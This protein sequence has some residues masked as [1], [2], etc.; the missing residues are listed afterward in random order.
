MLRADRATLFLVD[1][2]TSEIWSK[3]AQGAGM[4]EIRVP[5]G[6]GI[7]GTVAATG[8]TINIP[9]AYADPRFNPEVDRRTGY[10]T[11]TILCAPIRDGAGRGGRRGSQV[12][13]K[14][15]GPFTRDDEE[16]LAA[17][18]AQAFIALD[19]ARL[20]ESVV[21][22]KNYNESILSC[23]ATGVLTLDSYGVVTGV[24]PGL[25]SDLRRGRRRR[26]RPR[27]PGPARRQGQRGLRGATGHLCA[28]RRGHQP[29]TSSATT[30]SG[31]ESVNVNVSV[32]PL[33]DSKGQSLGVVVVADDITQEQRLMST[34][35]RYVTR[36]IAEEVLKS[37]GRCATGRH[38]PAGVHPVLR[39]PELHGDQRA[40]P[41]PEQ[42]V[43]FLNDYFSSWCR[44][45]S[46]SRARSTSSSATASWRC[47]ARP[48]AAPTIRCARCGPR[49]ACGAAC[50]AS[51]RCQRER[52][53]VEIEIGI[54]IS[55]GES[56]SGNI[57]SEQRMEYTVIGD[58]VNL[59]SRLE[60][61]TKNHPY[62]ILINDQIY[63]QVKDTF[64]CVLLGE[65]FVK[66]KAQAV[67]VY[68][69]ADPRLSGLPPARQRAREHRQRQ[70]RP[71]RSWPG[72]PTP[73]GSRP[74]R[75]SAAAVGRPLLVDH[76]RPG[77]HHPGLARQDFLAPLVDAHG[78][79][80]DAVALADAPRRPRPGR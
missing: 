69:V 50:A 67:R 52:G 72:P 13:N 10:R 38:T 35:C 9:D 33:L 80:P 3:V 29:R 15:A 20:F 73:T 22:M 24:N 11:R 6:R 12:L 77:R 26:G 53:A 30:L 63:E 54:G 42:I 60:G 62:K 32:V 2:R 61:L 78:L 27:R 59:A 43:E 46:P 49:S 18:S 36:E 14:A 41:Q 39:H 37:K 55:H 25:P 31:D 1:R 23:M 47:S 70:H 76:A 74:A 79:Q 44:R 4:V 57:G 8:E 5:I 7:A 75:R 71:R 34:L 17:L 19:N 51:T 56:I 16:L 58:S 40:V 66:G 21:T 68:G 64:D 48:S 65:E 28:E 45:S